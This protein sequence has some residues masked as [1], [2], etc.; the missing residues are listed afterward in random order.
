MPRELRSFEQLHRLVPALI[1][2]L[3]KQPELA[4]RAMANPLLAL[5]ELDIRLTPK[6]RKEAEYRIRF[7]ESE[8]AKAD[9]L[10][11]EVARHAGRSV[12]A[13]SS[14]DLENLLFRELRLER[15]EGH[16]SLDIP[17]EREPWRKAVA[18]DTASSGSGNADR[19]RSKGAVLRAPSMADPIEDL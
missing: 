7:P 4:A 13:E 3:N 19:A 8:R 17:V 9:A 12:D 11:A 18:A 14:K 5:E 2:R 16:P 1:G 15:A 10:D 6:V